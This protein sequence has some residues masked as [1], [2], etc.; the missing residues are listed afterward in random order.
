MKAQMIIEANFSSDEK[1]LNQLNEGCYIAFTRIYVKYWRQFY[2]YVLQLTRSEVET[3]DVLQDVFTDL[4]QLRD[5]LSHVRSLQSYIFSM[6]KGR[7][8]R[9]LYL[10]KR[11][12]KEQ[13]DKLIVQFYYSNWG[14]VDHLIAA[15][16]EENINLIVNM[17]PD[18][19]QKTFIKSRFQGYSHK[20]IAEEMGVSSATVKKQI[21]HSLKMI[22]KG[23][24]D[25]IEV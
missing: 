22:R 6:V 19:M 3:Q 21:Q 5:T 25:L 11:I 20:E 16:T 2:R 15:E 7:T 1:L 23:L 14:V 18:R 4:W 24:P 13:L 9:I 8:L 12:P 10:E 17:M